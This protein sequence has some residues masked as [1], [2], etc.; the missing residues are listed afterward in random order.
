MLNE[1]QE[2]VLEFLIDYISKNQFPPSVRDICAG[3]GIKST[4]TANG[5]L[6]KLEKYGYIK[7]GSQTS[8]SIE[9]VKDL[10]GSTR[11]QEETIDVPIVGKVSAGQPIT[12]IENIEFYFPIPSYYSKQGELFMLEISGESMIEAGIL[13]G[14]KV[15]VKKTNAAEHGEIVIAL[16]DDEATCKRLYNKNGQ[17]MLVP[18]NSTMKPIIPDNLTILGKV[19]SL[20]RENV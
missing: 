6:N 10:Y 17:V 16:I 19:I 9:I 13:D 15:L 20:F 8:R 7:R 12:A 14:D 5:D 4:S 11:N 2:K 18:E 3:V 1:R